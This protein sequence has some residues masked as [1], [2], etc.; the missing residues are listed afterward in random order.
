MCIRDSSGSELI[1]LLMESAAIKKHF[2]KYN[3]AQ[4]RKLPQYGIFTYED[5]NGI[6]HLAFNALKLV[7]NALLHFHRLVDCRLYLEQ[8]CKTFKLCPKYCHLQENVSSCS[9]YAINS[10]DGIC[11]GTE[12]AEAYNDK[13]LKAVAHIK[14]SPEDRIIKEKGRTPHEDG[15]VVVKDA[16]YIGYGFID[17]DMDIHSFSDIEAHIVRQHNTV[18]TESILGTYLLKHPNKAYL[19]KDKSMRF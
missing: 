4:K 10:C 3:R 18:E 1:A 6:R 2:P 17:K 14:P 11:R 5:R 19:L 13:V 7:P 15:I 9:H 16:L 8:I 12:T